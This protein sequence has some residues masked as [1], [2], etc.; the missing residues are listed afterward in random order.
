[1]GSYQRSSKAFLRDEREFGLIVGSALILLGGCWHYQNTSRMAAALC[2]GIACLLFTLALLFPRALVFPN[3]AWMTLA[4]CLSL[5][6]TPIVL[7]A[8]YFLVLMPIGVA[9][10]SLGWDPLRR[11]ASPKTSYWDPYNARQRE[12]R[13][14]EKMY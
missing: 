13:H 4:R 10:R 3:R 12:P 9:K 7:A 2:L 5:F 1:M 11:R 6:T 14:F 8:V